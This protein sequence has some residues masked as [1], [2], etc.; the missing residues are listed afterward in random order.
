MRK[1]VYSDYVQDILDSIADVE[2]FVG[3][4]SFEDFKKD[5]RTLYAVIRGIEIIGE[6]AKKIPTSIRDMY[7]DIPWKD[8]AGMRDKLI[9]DYFGVDAKVL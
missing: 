9:H 8:M 7:T 5:K 6:A 4:L 3:D 1:R 2:E